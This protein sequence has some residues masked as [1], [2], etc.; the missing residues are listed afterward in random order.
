MS[1]T[2]TFDAAMAAGAVTSERGSVYGHPADDFARAERLKQVVADCKDPLL[3][4]ALEMICV[5][6]ARLIHTPTHVDSWV[7]IA[8]YARTGVMILDRE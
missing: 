2:E 5:K 6:M 3:R 8:G 7:D 1:A 4:H